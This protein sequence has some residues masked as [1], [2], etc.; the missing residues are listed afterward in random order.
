MPIGRA[1]SSP[2]LLLI[3]DDVRLC[4]LVKEYLE[5]MGYAVSME[6]YRTRRAGAGTQGDLPRRS[7]S[8]SCCPAWTASRCCGA[9]DSSTSPV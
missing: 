1:T 5:T 3:E 2:R 7:F 4:R 9:A 6:H 8:T